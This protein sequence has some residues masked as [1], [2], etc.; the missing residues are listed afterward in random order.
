MEKSEQIGEASNQIPA[1]K[2]I[3][4]IGASAGGLNALKTFFSEVPENS[5]LAYV[6]VVHLAPDHKS[7]LSEL[8]QPFC[9]MPVQQVADTI[10][11]EPDHV[12]VIPPGANLNSIDTHLR[13]SEL[14]EKRH[15]RAPIDHFFRTLSKTHDGNAIGIILTGTGSDGALGIKEIKGN[16][17]LVIVQDPNEAE[18]DGMPQSAIAT[19]SVDFILPVND[20]PGRVMRFVNS[21][22]DLPDAISIG[23]T[24][25]EEQKLLQKIFVQ[26]RA[27]T[28]R[29][30][31][32]YK[33]STIMR[34]LQ[35]RMQLAQTPSLQEYLDYMRS[36]PD[37]AQALSDDFL[38]TVT[39][40]FRDPEVFNYLGNKVLPRLIADKKQDEQVRIWSV[41]CASGEEAYSLAILALEI[42][43]NHEVPPSIQIFASDLHSRS[44]KLARDGFYPGD[45]QVDMT[46]ERLQRFFI[47]E[48]GGYRIR[49]EVREC[50]IFTPHNLLSDPPFS[51]MD[52]IVCRNL[53]IYLKRETQP[54]VIELFHYALRPDGILVIGN[55][56]KLDTRDLF[57]NIHK[58]YSIFI[59]RN[60]SGPEPR[61]PVFP[62]SYSQ[63]PDISKMNLEQDHISFGKL[64]QRLIERYAP[65]SILLTLEH[66]IVH[67]SEHAGR[68]LTHRGGEPTHDIFKL[69]RDDLKIELRSIIH[70]TKEKNKIFRSNPVITNIDGKEERIIISSR[71]T[72]GL[73]EE[74]FI[75]V[76]FEEYDEVL[77]SEKEM[78]APASA[79]Q[80][81][82][83]ARELEVELEVAQQRLQAIIE[84]YDTTREEMK[85][86][87]EELLSSNE[88]LHSTMEELETS[89]EELQ[90]IN[91]ELSTVNQENRHKVEELSQL[92]SDLQN[93]LAA[94][95]IATLF[96]DRN[97]RIM[98]F[99]PRLGELFNVRL[100]DRGRPITDLTHKLG[101]INL[102]D[103]A[104]QVLKKLV[105]FEK[106]VPDNQGAWYLIRISPYRSTN[107]R[108]EGVV[109]TL[110]DVTA[111][112]T[113]EQ[114]LRNSENKLRRTQ[115]LLSFATETSQ[116]GWGTW[117]MNTGEA[118]WDKR[119]CQILGIE[120][121][122]I[123]VE[124]WMNCILPDDRIK[125][126]EQL[127]EAASKEGQFELE[128][129]IRIP[130]KKIRHI[131]T[132][133][134]FKKPEG[135]ASVLGTA[136]IRDVTNL[137]NLQQQKDDFIAMV[138]HELK[139]P[140]SVMK[141]YIKMIEDDLRKSGDQAAVDNLLKVDSQIKRISILINDLLDVSRIEAGRFNFKEE[142]FD[143]DP[144][145]D[146]VIESMQFVSPHNLKKIGLTGKSVIGDRERTGQVIINLIS[147]AVKFSSDKKEVIIRLSSEN[148]SLTLSVQ[149]FGIGIEKGQLNKVF[150]RFSTILAPSKKSKG[151]GIGLFISSEIIRRQNGRI[152]V[153]STKD[154]GSTFS[155]SLPVADNQ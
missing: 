2:T 29:D 8:L 16:N 86:S 1:V 77:N 129:M 35:R 14:E 144:L 105:P 153:D 38:I 56:E 118:E 52:M 145:V 76:I 48:D 21:T 149:D 69:I 27:R 19:G 75:L 154:K 101:N 90:S 116:L 119:G 5:G 24:S 66:Q 104:R 94:T 65:P 88:E 9:N 150:E 93:L 20:I 133:G 17:G 147:N 120:E 63:Y 146:E 61:L 111:I 109:I 98:R 92:S 143:F 102:I 53:M 140:V 84:E 134:A 91:E 142:R 114:E 23:E 36:N 117:N 25:T 110:V 128:Y 70:A 96:L 123:T 112:K 40:F 33:I 51:K 124:K 60:I 57:R 78:K 71:Y 6:V 59:K 39:S 7:M 58:N 155:F 103:D 28:N 72:N 55:S 139:T 64:H 62:I 79:E 31:N 132:T 106:E 138:S 127:K 30:F 100:T 3:V 15:K 74:K 44:L 107:D 122:N 68:Y 130:D 85:A 126:M 54:E 87:N 97:F 22:P 47:K 13:L 99:T 80:S 32:R 67:L 12:Y 11:L 137:V 37:E 41:G 34:R 136:L 73:N 95:D 43:R 148:N 82:V 50:V 131:H 83:N 89:K 26:I 113:A 151:L 125:V 108:I 46:P 141:G 45:I 121:S 152:W 115:D 49:K 18:Y 135:S 10:A 4:G 42:S 81:K